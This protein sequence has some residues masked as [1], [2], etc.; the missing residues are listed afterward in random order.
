MGYDTVSIQCIHRYFIKTTDSMLLYINN[1][2]MIKTLGCDK[3]AS[4]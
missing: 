4:E 3:K 2:N 1:K